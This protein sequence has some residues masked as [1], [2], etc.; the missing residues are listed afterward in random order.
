MEQKHTA[1]LYSNQFIR[2]LSASE[3]RKR[4]LI[5]Q[6]STLH[7]FGDGWLSAGF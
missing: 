2:L 1:T 5:N 3:I 6:P 4:K 7:C